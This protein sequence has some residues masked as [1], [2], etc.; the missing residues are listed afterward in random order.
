MQLQCICDIEFVIKYRGS[1]DFLNEI[2]GIVLIMMKNVLLQERGGLLVCD[3][4]YNKKMVNV[5]G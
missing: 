3:I 5:G 4:K 2:T 1:I